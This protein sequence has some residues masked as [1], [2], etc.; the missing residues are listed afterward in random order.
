MRINAFLA[1]S[2]LAS[3]RK[4]EFFVTEGRVTINGKSATL[5]DHVEECDLVKLDG[6]PIILVEKKY[7]LVNKP[8]GYTSTVDDPHADKKVVDLI[9]EKG[10]FPVGRLDKDSEGLMIL[11][12]DG[13]F[14]QKLIHPKFSHERE[15][16]VEVRLPFKQRS[17]KLEFAIKFFKCGIRLDEK[18]TEPC[19]IKLLSQIGSVATFDIIMKEGMKRQIRRTFEKA[20]LEVINL[21][22]IRIADYILG[23]LEPGESKAFAV[24]EGT[25]N[26]LI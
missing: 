13:E 23:D 15:Y 10:L 4:A 2:G 14:A 16:I 17:E 5:T 3:R 9:E 11:T 7:Y 12:N 18:R 8:V 6:N 20:H 22:R 26:D 24:N 19:E 21:K 25:K 1:K